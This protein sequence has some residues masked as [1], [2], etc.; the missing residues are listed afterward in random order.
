MA[1]WYNKVEDDGFHSFNV[2]ASTLYEHY[3]ELLNAYDNRA[4]NAMAESF[5]AKI[6]LFRANF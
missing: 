4:S 5:N 2:I 1:R 3:D 6:K